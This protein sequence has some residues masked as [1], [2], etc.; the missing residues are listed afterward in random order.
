MIDI[1]LEKVEKENIR[2]LWPKV[3]NH[4]QLVADNAPDELT[5]Y[6]IKKRL[7]A[8]DETLLLITRGEEILA[9]MVASIKTFDTGKR[10]LYIPVLG[11]R[12]LAEW[13]PSVHE[14]LI[15][16]ARQADC[17]MV[18]ALGARRGWIKAIPGIDTSNCRVTITLEI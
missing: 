14:Q 7:F 16:L 8:G 5:V 9:C 1:R 3:K 13:M 10:A 17:D 18:Q 2:L 12:E 6:G 15:D 11:G 4:L